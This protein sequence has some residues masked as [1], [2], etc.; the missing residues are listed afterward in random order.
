LST[1]Y[2]SYAKTVDVNTRCFAAH[3]KSNIQYTA[4]IGFPTRASLFSVPVCTGT[5]DLTDLEM[6]H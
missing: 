5:K 3:N 6:T 4:P 2:S 1:K